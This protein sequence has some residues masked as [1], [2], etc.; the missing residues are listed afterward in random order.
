MGFTWECHAH[1]YMKR[2][3]LFSQLLG[4]PRAVEARLLEQPA[5]TL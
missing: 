1:R 3:Q 4:G 5:A 2:A